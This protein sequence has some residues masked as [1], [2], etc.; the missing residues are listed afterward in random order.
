MIKKKVYLL[1]QRKYFGYD[2]S[3][4]E[5]IEE[6]MIIGYFT[7]LDSMLI[8]KELCSQHGIEKKYVDIKCFDMLLNN[9]QKYIYILSHAYSK[10]QDDGTLTDY[11]YIFEPK[12]NKNECL[13]LKNTLIRKD[14]FKYSIDRDYSINPPDGF[15]IGKYELNC[16]VYPIYK[17]FN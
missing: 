12:L 11:E 7:S 10:Y 14:K 5:D 6:R 16:M 15:I 1:Q 13:Q 2:A 17:S 3:D 9:N 4:N 8:A